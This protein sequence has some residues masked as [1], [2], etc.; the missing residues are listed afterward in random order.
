M[1]PYLLVQPRQLSVVVVN[2]SQN[3]MLGLQMMMQRLASS[4]SVIS[5]RCVPLG[6]LQTSQIS[7][8]FTIIR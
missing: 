1:L 3:P 5:K 2:S 8:L 6:W 7:E 4:S